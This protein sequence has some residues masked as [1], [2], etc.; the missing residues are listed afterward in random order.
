MGL[1]KVLGDEL[2]YV[3]ELGSDNGVISFHSKLY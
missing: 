3:S 2:T 1:V